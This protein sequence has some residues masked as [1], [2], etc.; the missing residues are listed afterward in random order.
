MNE[1]MKE[2][3][4]I[5]LTRIWRQSSQMLMDASAASHAAIIDEL[6]A[7]DEAT[8]KA[9]ENERSALDNEEEALSALLFAIQD[10]AEDLVNPRN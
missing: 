8:K 4:I 7:Y 10:E 6:H 5:K 1:E 2:E 3:S 9:V